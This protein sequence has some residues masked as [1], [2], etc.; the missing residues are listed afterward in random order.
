MRSKIVIEKPYV[1]YVHK[2][3]IYADA[4]RLCANITML[5]P[6][7]KK[8]E[9]KVLYFE[10]DSAFAD[11]LT[12]NRSDA[13]VMG[14]LTTAMENDMDIQF[15][16]PMSEKLY[17]QMV[18][19]FIPIVTENNPSW[20]SPIKLN[21]PLISE[22]IENTG[23]VATGC[24]GGV[25]S[26]YTIVKH[27]IREKIKNYKLTHLLFASVGTLDD[28]NGRITSYF[29]N[30][31]K[32]M[33][34]I[35]EE[36]DTKAVGVYS[37]LHEFYKFPYKGF[38][39]FYAT[40]YGACAYALQRIL[41]VYYISAGYPISEFTLNVNKVK[42]YDASVFDVFTVGC[43]DTE[44]LSFYVTGIEA[45][46]IDR[47]NYIA[48]DKTAQ[49]Y[50]T[51]CSIELEGSEKRQN[52]INCGHCHKCLPALV[53]LYAGNNLDKF[54]NVFD[55]EEFKRKKGKNIG[56]MM[57][58]TNTSYRR[59]AITIAKEK[60]VKIPVAA[61]LWYWGFYKPFFGLMHLLK[62]NRLVRDV[63][64]RLNLDIKIHG[65]R[66]AKYDAFNKKLK[67]K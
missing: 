41:R 10:I 9:R 56:K 1:E 67:S 5:N 31:L 51:T 13:F 52:Y 58:I 11:G 23:G 17:F 24:S 35:A 54:K 50:L 29:K 27:G 42:E 37:N 28:D 63:Y 18:N 34:H 25:D 32:R 21:G 2:S 7:N 22:R 15:E 20:I 12:V 45:T 59:Q 8:T 60:K 62:N 4:A 53:H 19:Q 16:T 26:F 33:E 44:S 66:N 57:A 40:T 49:K 55:I 30:T 14:L 36:T 38:S 47:I 39:M 46:R 3:K 65:Y 64:Y 6:N 48:K 43:M 61:Y